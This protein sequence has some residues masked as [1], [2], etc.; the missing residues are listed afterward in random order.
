MIGS[1]PQRLPNFFALSHYKTPSVHFHP[2]GSSK[3]L[4]TPAQGTK[5][6]LSKLLPKLWVTVQMRFLSLLRA[7]ARR[8]GL[9]FPSL[10]LRV[11]LPAPC[12]IQ[13]GREQKSCEGITLGLCLNRTVPWEA[14]ARKRKAWPV[15]AYLSRL[16]R[17]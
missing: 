10:H 8:Q 2:V 11:C 13:T 17:H 14:G 15:H 6:L 9:L 12:R 3:H 5:L 7:L 16:W 4:L 1:F